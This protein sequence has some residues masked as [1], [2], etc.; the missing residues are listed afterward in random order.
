MSLFKEY[1]I[2][3]GTL[4]FDLDGKEYKSFGG[5]LNEN[6]MRKQDLMS[7]LIV[8]M[9][10]N[11]KEFLVSK[12][13]LNAHAT[14]MLANMIQLGVPLETSILLLNQKIIQDIYRQIDNSDGI[15]LLL[16]IL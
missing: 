10:D 5:T 2:G 11:A 8:A 1:K 13:G 12:L 6:G 15:S 7:S 4:K 3:L 16:E 14:R 9:T